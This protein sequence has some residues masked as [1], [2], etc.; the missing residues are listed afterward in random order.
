MGGVHNFCVLDFQCQ[1]E[2]RFHCLSWVPGQMTVAP[3]ASTFPQAQWYIFLADVYAGVR[4]GV[5]ARAARTRASDHTS[6]LGHVFL[7]QW[8]SSVVGLCLAW[9]GR[10]RHELIRVLPAASFG[11]PWESRPLLRIRAPSLS[12]LVWP[13]LRVESLGGMPL[14]CGSPPTCWPKSRGIAGERVHVQIWSAGGVL[15]PTLSTKFS[16]CGVFI[17]SLPYQPWPPQV[18]GA[19]CRFHSGML[20]ICCGTAAVSPS[21]SAWTMHL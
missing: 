16:Q 19:R 11:S 1:L 3:H 21:N 5:R 18:L 13:D 2:N 12:S 7:A 20:K 9:A 15:G 14:H 4:L 10:T 6:K 17:P 8:G